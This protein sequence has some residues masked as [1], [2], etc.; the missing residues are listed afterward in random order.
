MSIFFENAQSL[1]TFSNELQNTKELKK[2]KD[3][4]ERIL[5]LLQT[6]LK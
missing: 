6:V 1:T 4:A 5:Y 2:K 3:K